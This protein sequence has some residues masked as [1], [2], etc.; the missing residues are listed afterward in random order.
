VESYYSADRFHFAKLM[1]HAWFGLL[2]SHDQ[3]Q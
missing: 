2:S 3:Q 1:A